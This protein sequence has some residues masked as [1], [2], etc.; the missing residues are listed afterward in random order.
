M[1]PIELETKRLI[2][3]DHVIEDLET[4]HELFSD[5]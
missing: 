1:E 4:H 2:L 3:R 5:T